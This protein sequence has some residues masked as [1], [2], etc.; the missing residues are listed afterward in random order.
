M[1]YIV[2]SARIVY[3]VRMVVM[4]TLYTL[5]SMYML[6]D[7]CRVYTCVCVIVFGWMS[8]VYVSVWFGDC[9]GIVFRGSVCAYV[10]Y[11]C[12]RFP[13]TYF[14]VSFLCGVCLLFGGGKGRGMNGSRWE[15]HSGEGNYCLLHLLS[16]ARHHGFLQA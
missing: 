15:G 16:Q 1:V 13:Y 2:H 8:F 3:H 9:F 5:G 7:L 12:I 6:S 11:L 14:D 4:Y 10:Q